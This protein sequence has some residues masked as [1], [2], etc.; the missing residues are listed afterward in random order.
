MD[1]YVVFV[2][3]VEQLVMLNHF[4]YTDTGKSILLSI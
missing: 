2:N 1:V 4:M 3:F